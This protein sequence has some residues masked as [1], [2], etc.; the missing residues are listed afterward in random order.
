MYS[1]YIKTNMVLM[2]FSYFSLF[3]IN[4]WQHEDVRSFFNQ[5]DKRA[6]RKGIYSM[7]KKILLTV[8]LC[9]LF[10]ASSSQAASL[11]A[12]KSLK[13]SRISTIHSSWGVE[14]MGFDDFARTIDIP[15][16]V[17]VAVIDTGVDTDHYLLKDR[18]TAGYDFGENKE[19]PEDIV[20]HGTYMCGI[21]ADC[22]KNVKNI[23][24]MPLKVSG[25]DGILTSDAECRAIDFAVKS[26]AK[27]IS[28]SFAADLS[29]DHDIDDAI[30]QAVQNGVTVVVA[31]GNDGKDTALKCPAHNKNAIT[32]SALNKD[33]QLAEYSNYGDAIDYAAPAS[34][35][36]GADLKD[37][38]RIDSGTSVAA[39][40]VAAAA[41]MIYAKYPDATV[42][43]VREMLTKSC[44]RI[45]L[46]K[47]YGHGMINL[48][49]LCK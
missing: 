47:Y 7:F 34:Y 33:G 40:H 12:N 20:G 29:E 39:P 46:N 6:F 28:I 13:H 5:A 23:K 21:I 18:L 27:V 1:K 38:S 17:K 16:E 49:N 45:G 2:I 22:T 3:L 10:A 11:P 48:R 14:K 15:A 43:Q 44:D 30:N 26:G 41:A 9:S 4:S 25:S 19:T 24:I 42:D 32:V 35:V 8:T 31:A 36:L 37:G